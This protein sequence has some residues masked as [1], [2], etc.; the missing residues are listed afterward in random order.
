MGM[1]AGGL[2][3]DDSEGIEGAEGEDRENRFGAQRVDEHGGDERAGFNGKARRPEVTPEEA[4]KLRRLETMVSAL[5]PVVN[6]EPWIVELLGTVMSMT[7]NEVRCDD[8]ALGMRG[9]AQRD[10]DANSGADAESRADA[11]TMLN[12]VQA[13]C[14]P[15][16][17]AQ[18]PD[19]LEARPQRTSSDLRPAAP[20]T[21]RSRGRG[22]R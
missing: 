13:L 12:R 9:R 16:P 17:R 11:V 6:M 22:G 19:A 15:P 2:V 14:N 3:P 20:A 5:E 21:Q 18:P 8:G 7:Q 4:E 1:G 10:A